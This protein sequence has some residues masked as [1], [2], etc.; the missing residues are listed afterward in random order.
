V[1]KDEQD[2]LG[3][4][5]GSRTNLFYIYTPRWI[6][7]SAG[8][9]VLHYLCHALNC[10]GQDAFLVLSDFQTK[11]SP[12]VNPDL[13]TPI[14][15]NE[16]AQAHFLS[17]R[18]PIA[19]Y[20][21]TIPGNPL[22]A[23]RVVR[24]LLNYAGALGGENVFPQNEYVIAFSKNIASHYEKMNKLTKVPVLFL[25]PVNP[26]EFKFNREKKSFQLVYAGKY[27]NFVGVP[28]HVGELPTVE[29]FRDG[30]SMQSR[31]EVKKLLSQASVLYSFE[32]TSLITEAVLSGTPV[33]LVKNEFFTEMIAEHEL[34]HGGIRE[35]DAPDALREANESVHEGALQYLKELAR[36][37]KSL[38]QFI[39]ESSDKFRD[40]K[41]SHP[42]N[43]RRDR[44]I[45]LNHKLTLSI[46]ILRSK[47]PGTLFRM[48]FFYIR[49]RIGLKALNPKV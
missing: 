34:G 23:T 27:R 42:I 43:L 49:R 15:T 26:M 10:A 8:I 18:N 24:Y 25:P 6:N 30:K 9:K 14:L 45:F 33:L 19:I 46:Q 48:I 16:Q 20:P 17:N 47:G 35:F 32:N 29:I 7:S 5:F 21:E 2:A 38:S 3:R 11:E 13:K 36:F 22:G 44:L 31:D 37:E 41:Q 12:R 40:I 1:I 28:P 39:L 4:V